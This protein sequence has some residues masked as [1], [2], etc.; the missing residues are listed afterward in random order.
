MKPS[1]PIPNPED[2]CS[3]AILDGA[4]CRVNRKGRAVLRHP[5]IGTAVV[6]FRVLPSGNIVAL[7]HPYGFLDGFANLTCLDE[8]LRL[9]WFF[10]SPPDGGLYA[11]LGAETETTLTARSTGGVECTFDVRDGQLLSARVITALVA[12]PL[13]V[14]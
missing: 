3:L 1:A 7:E 8:R 5:P 13:P 6:Q 12:D 11:E 2:P 4:L 10:A 9:L 14:G